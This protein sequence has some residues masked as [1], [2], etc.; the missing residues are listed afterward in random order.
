MQFY[1]FHRKSRNGT[2]K[3]S[4]CSASHVQS[5]DIWFRYASPEHITWW[6]NFIIAKLPRCIEVVEGLPT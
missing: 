6:T 2:L 3:S 1:M 5:R 4:T